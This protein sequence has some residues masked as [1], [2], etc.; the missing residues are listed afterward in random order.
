MNLSNL[1]NPLQAAGMEEELDDI[2]IGIAS[3]ENIRSW[4]YGEL[5]KNS[6]PSKSASPRPKPSALGRTAK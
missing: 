4:S 3:P 2:K 5:K 1:F 6:M